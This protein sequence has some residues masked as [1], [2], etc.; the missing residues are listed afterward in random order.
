[1]LSR[2][3]GSWEVQS[4]LKLLPLAEEQAY[5]ILFRLLERKLIEIRPP[6]A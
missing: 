5:E 6:S 1:V 4:I 3:N 2:I